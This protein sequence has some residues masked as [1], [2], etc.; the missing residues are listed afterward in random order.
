MLANNKPLVWQFTASKMGVSSTCPCGSGKRSKCFVEWKRKYIRV[1]T[2]R[3]IVACVECNKVE[4]HFCARAYRALR[5]ALREQLMSRGETITE[6]AILDELEKLIE[7][8][9]YMAR[10]IRNE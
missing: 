2:P 7:E 4:A 10:K 6:N 8:G 1:A 9:S 3:A 5:R